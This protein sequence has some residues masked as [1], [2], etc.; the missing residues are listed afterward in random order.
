MVSSIEGLGFPAG[1]KS[2][3]ARGECRPLLRALKKVVP[4]PADGTR[5]NIVYS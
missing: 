2:R 3:H 4:R 5:K 1:R